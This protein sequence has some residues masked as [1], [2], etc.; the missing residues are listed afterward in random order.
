MALMAY[1]LGD[2]NCFV[3]GKTVEAMRLWNDNSG[4]GRL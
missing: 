3:R 2:T 4:M 1:Q